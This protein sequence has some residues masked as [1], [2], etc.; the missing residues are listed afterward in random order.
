MSDKP[1][2]VFQGLCIRC[3]GGFGT[4][5]MSHCGACG[6]SVNSGSLKLC[7]ACAIKLHK[8]QSCRLNPDE[9]FRLEQ[10]RKA[11]RTHIQYSLFFDKETN[12]N[13]IKSRA[14]IYA[15]NSKKIQDIASRIETDFPGVRIVNVLDALAM[16]FI[17]IPALNRDTFSEEIRTKYDCVLADMD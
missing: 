11:A 14:E 2:F 16:M 10:E 5:D 7:Q 4:C 15:E 9:V 17:E 1:S 12:D 6:A 8:C 3:V 13:K